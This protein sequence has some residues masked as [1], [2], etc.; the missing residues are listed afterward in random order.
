MS[1]L[2]ESDEP[3]SPKW[4]DD[5]PHMIPLP[6]LSDG[7]PIQFV[8]IVDKGITLTLD[9]GSIYTPLGVMGV[10]QTN[11]MTYVATYLKDGYLFFSIIRKDD[12]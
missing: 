11:R 6:P 8:K 4:F 2:L 1:G 9:D 12:E 5:D 7:K 3:I 10:N